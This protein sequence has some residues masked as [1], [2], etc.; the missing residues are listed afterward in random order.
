LGVF[1][2][3]SETKVSNELFGQQI[4]VEQ[5]RVPPEGLLKGDNFIISSSTSCLYW[6][7]EVRTRIIGIVLILREGQEQ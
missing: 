6:E 7:G 2:K 4:Q 1:R 5:P 3:T